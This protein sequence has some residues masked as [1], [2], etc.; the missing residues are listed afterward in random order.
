MNLNKLIIT[1]V[2]FLQLACQSNK[3]FRDNG[4]N[5]VGQVDEIYRNYGK[6]SA[7]NIVYHYTINGKTYKGRG[8]ISSI[9]MSTKNKLV[10]RFFRVVYLNESPEVSRILISRYDFQLL[11][12]EYPDSLKWIK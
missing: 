7:Y 4:V 6:G 5:T 3:E 10:N 2:F 8:S 12:Y 11:D 9:E 1:I